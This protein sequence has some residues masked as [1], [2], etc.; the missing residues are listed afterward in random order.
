MVAP[1][2]VCCNRNMTVYNDYALTTS[3][4]IILFSQGKG[5]LSWTCIRESQ[6]N[7]EFDFIWINLMILKSFI[8]SFQGS[9]VDG[10]R[11]PLWSRLHG[12][13]LHVHN[14]LARCS[15]YIAGEITGCL[16][17]FSLQNTPSGI[18]VRIQNLFL[19]QNYANCT[20]LRDY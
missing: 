6:L 3:V 9:T 15:R 17:I 18:H 16:L 5:K 4:P 19:H 1:L 12:R 13:F 7:S 20:N 11:L 8:P 2:S 14:L 10:G